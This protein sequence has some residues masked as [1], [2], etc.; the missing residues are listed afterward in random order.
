[1]EGW[2]EKKFLDTIVFF[3]THLAHI[4]IGV[5]QISLLDFGLVHHQD[6]HVICANYVK[7]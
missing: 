2:E 6:F 7:K 5:G 1:M 4:K 3:L